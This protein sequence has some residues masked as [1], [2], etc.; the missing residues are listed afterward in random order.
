MVY[1]KILF[2]NIKEYTPSW[3][4]TIPYAQVTKTV[5]GRRPQ[6]I[7]KF[8]AQPNIKRFW[9]FVQRNIQKN[10][11]LWQVWIFFNAYLIFHICYD[12][13]LYVYKLN[14]EHRTLDHAFAIEKEYKRKKRLEE[15]G[16]ESE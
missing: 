9:R 1:T 6:V 10:P 13:W 3:F 4:R 8:N 2:N 14:N 15:E 12:P 5:L 7:S 11:A 16:G